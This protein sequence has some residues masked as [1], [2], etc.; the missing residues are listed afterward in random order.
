M[1]KIFVGDCTPDLAQAAANDSSDAC[2]IDF[3]NYTNDINSGT[4]YTS[5]SD[6][7]APS[8]LVQVLNQADEI[9]YAPPAQWS[10]VKKGISLQQRWTEFYCLYFNDKKSVKGLD[11]IQVPECKT[12]MLEL[13]DARSAANTK[14]LWVAGCSISHGVGVELDERYGYLLADKLD[15]PVSFLTKPGSS[16]NWAADQI[17]RSD[18]Q[19][20]DTV[21]WGLTSLSRQAFMDDDCKVFHLNP[22]FYLEYKEARKIQEIIP[23]ELLTH[24]KNNLF[25]GLQDIHKVINFCS[26]MNVTLV[27]ASM[28]IDY[29]G[30]HYIYDL[31]NFKQLF[32]ITGIEASERFLDIG[33]DGRH[34]GA[35]THKWYADQVFNHIK[36][37]EK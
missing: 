13:A 26:K 29:D 12:K 15:L 22:P 28:L 18:I 25:H 5:L 30:L 19:P 8:A 31:P 14:Q 34:P 27:L 1:I 23:F 4:Y 37:I 11:N 7:P 2:L 3:S 10:D 24:D 21:V 35:I 16:L 17:L 20:G 33:S 36:Q 6:L 9:I 32:C